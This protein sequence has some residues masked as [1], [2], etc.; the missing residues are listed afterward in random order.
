MID[1][2]GLL[3]EVNLRDHGEVWGA[4]WL[5]ESL[6]GIRTPPLLS[7]NTHRTTPY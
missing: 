3:S 7:T 6:G 5:E 1:A 4:Q 2:H